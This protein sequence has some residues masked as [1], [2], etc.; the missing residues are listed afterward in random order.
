MGVLL[1]EIRKKKPIERHKG[2]GLIFLKYK[3][4]IFSAL[5]DGY[6][7]QAIYDKML[8]MKLIKCKKFCLYRWIKKERRMMK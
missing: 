4:D 2:S 5:D 1:D 3:E 7:I 8:E 6:T